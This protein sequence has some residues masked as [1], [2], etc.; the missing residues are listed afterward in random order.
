MVS[1]LTMC[2]HFSSFWSLF[3]DTFYK[4]YTIRTGGLLIFYLKCFFCFCLFHKKII[5]S[6]QWKKT[7]YYKNNILSHPQNKQRIFHFKKFCV[8]FQI[9]FFSS[10]LKHFFQISFRRR[11]EKNYWREQDSR[12]KNIMHFT[13]NRSLRCTCFFFFLI[14]CIDYLKKKKNS[15]EWLFF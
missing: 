12:Q 10:F 11:I 1:C 5:S 7:N 15:F 2:F 9:F 13:G 3:G 6:F 4:P 14:H 8:T